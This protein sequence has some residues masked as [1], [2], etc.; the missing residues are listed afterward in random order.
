[1]REKEGRERQ[2]LLLS[3]EEKYQREK[4]IGGTHTF[5][6]SPL[7]CEETRKKT[8]LVCHFQN[9][10]FPQHNFNDLYL[11]FINKI[12]T[13]QIKRNKLKKKGCNLQSD[14]SEG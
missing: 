4:D 1:M 10:P 3:T 9:Y 5:I 2:F 12:T 7:I 13:R 8:L 14:H 11:I 6:L